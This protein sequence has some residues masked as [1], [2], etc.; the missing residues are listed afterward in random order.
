MEYS[1]RMTKTTWAVAAGATLLWAGTVLA[2]PTAQQKCEAAKNAAAASTR[3]AAT[4]EKNLVLNGDSTK[5][6]TAVGK[7]DTTLAATW[8][9]LEQA[10][11]NKGTTCPSTGDEG[12]MQTFSPPMRTPW[13]PPCTRPL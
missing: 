10:A 4:A 7:C 8:T 12:A 3:P 13:P 5:Y 2:T 9:K 11:V 1:V 6:A